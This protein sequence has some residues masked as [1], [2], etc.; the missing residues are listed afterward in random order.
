MLQKLFSFVDQ[1]SAQENPDALQYQEVLTV[2][3]LLSV[4]IKVPLYRDLVT[5]Y[6]I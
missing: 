4:Y 2:G 3:N 6:Y 1:T 5:I